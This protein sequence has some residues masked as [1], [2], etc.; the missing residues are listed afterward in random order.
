MIR[1]DLHTHS[2]ASKDGGIRLKQYEKLISNRILDVIAITDHDRIDFAQ[3]AQELL[4]SKHIIV[5]QEITTINGDILGLYLKSPIPAGLSAEEA[6]HEVHSQEGIVC[7]PHPFETVRKGVTAEVL[8]QIKKHVDLIEA[9]NGRAVVQNFST[10]AIS[11][12]ED[13]KKLLVASSDAHGYKGI[14]YTYTL[15]RDFPKNSKDLLKLLNTTELVAQKPPLVTLT[16][17]ARNMIIN[18]IKVKK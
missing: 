17:P 12:G 6:V 1:I 7:I 10:K 9:H 11:W 4:G 3:E 18:K 5:G 2:S 13:N 8:D 15:I 16:Y 14:G